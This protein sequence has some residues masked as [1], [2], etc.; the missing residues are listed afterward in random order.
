[1]QKSLDDFALGKLRVA[2]GRVTL[3][4]EY[5]GLGLFNLGEFLTAQQ[6]TW[7]LR[8]DK[9][10]KDNWRGDL[11]SLSW[12]NCLSF[13]HRNISPFEHPIL[14]GLGAAFEK[15]RT[16][17]DGANENFL[18]ASVLYQPMFFRGPG[19]KQVLDPDY[20]ECAQN[21]V[22]CR[23]VANLKVEDCFGM[24]GLITRVELRQNCGIDLTVTGYSNLGRALNHFVNRLKANRISDGTSISLRESLNIK[25]PG[26]KIRGLLVKKRK[27]PFDLEEQQTCKTFFRI[28]GIEYVGNELFS[29][30]CSIWNVSG[31][32]NRQKSFM[33]KFYNNILGLNTRTSHFAVNVNRTCFFCSKS[34]PPLNADETFIHLF[35]SCGTTRSYQRTFIRTCF[36]EMGNLPE[37]DEKKLWFL[38]IYDNAIFDFIVAAF[39]TF[40]FCIWE[41]KL[42]KNVPSYHTLY[43][44]FLEMFRNTCMHNQQIRLSGTELNYELCRNIFG[45]RRRIPDGEE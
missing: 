18:K 39:L 43:T 19:D 32:T 24:Y 45:G 30:I 11:F 13:T 4:P 35:F 15:V 42:R 2:R 31:F 8:A 6:S 1:M 17:H 5:G 34:N 26:A 21:L 29:K 14:H 7:V 44:E 41:H 9:S 12:G 25:K 37:I 28:T 36:S 10:L 33:F 40:Q 3:P 16:C 27:K 23:K 38:G 22:L 20:L